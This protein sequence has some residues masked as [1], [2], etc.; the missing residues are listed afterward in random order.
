MT[1]E[2]DDETSN[3]VIIPRN[4]EGPSKVLRPGGDPLSFE[5]FPSGHRDFVEM[6]LTDEGVE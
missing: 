5:V 2:C 4:P 3:M 1:L 6:F